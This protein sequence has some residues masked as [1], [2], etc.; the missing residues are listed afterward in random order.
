VTSVR[1][2][3]LAPGD[4]VASRSR[5]ERSKLRRELGRLDAVC[6]LIA[7]IVVLDTFGAVAR[8]GAQTLTW[9]VLVAAAFSVPAGLVIAELGSAFPDQGGPHVWT[10]LAFGRYAGS[11]VNGLTWVMASSRT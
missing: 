2:V 5:A 4:A 7:A 9:L 8:G 3:E 1:P 11:L 6:L 10:R